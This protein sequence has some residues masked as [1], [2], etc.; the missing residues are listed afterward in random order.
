MSDYALGVDIGGTKIAVGA[1]DRSGTVRARRTIPTDVEAGFAAGLARLAQ[2][3]DETMAEGNAASGSPVG[4]GLGAPAPST[5]QAGESTT[6]TPCRAGKG[7][8]S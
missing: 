7:T 8:T 4:I 5:K 1:I 6:A 2:A 3:I